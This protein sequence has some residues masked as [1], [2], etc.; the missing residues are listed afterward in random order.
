MISANGSPSPSLFLSHSEV[1]Q[2]VSNKPY[3]NA[4]FLLP[5]KLDLSK[6]A[7][8]DG[9]AQYVLAELSVLL[10]FAEVMPAPTTPP[11]LLAMLFGACS[12]C[13]W[14]GVVVGDLGRVRLCQRL[15]RARPLNV[16]LGL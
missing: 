8:T 14:G 6:L 10:A 5:T 9:V 2:N 4:A 1:L 16:H 13:L 7:F 12:Y 3:L 15:A 11:C